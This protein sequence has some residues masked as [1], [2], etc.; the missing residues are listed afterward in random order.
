MQEKRFRNFTL[1]FTAF[2]T[3]I[4]GMASCDTKVDLNAPYM[5]VPVVFGL[6]DAELDTQALSK[7][8]Y[9]ALEITNHESGHKSVW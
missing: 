7:E 9:D 4:M 5:S 6:L 1:G 8:V 3:L 2:A